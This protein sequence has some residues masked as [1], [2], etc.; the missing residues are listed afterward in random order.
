MFD[1]EKEF[2]FLVLVCMFAFVVWVMTTPRPPGPTV[3]VVS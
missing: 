1:L 2:K 3:L